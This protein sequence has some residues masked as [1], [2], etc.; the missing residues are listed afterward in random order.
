MV[1][2]W[3]AMAWDRWLIYVV[4][5]FDTVAEYWE[6]VATGSPTRTSRPARRKPTRSGD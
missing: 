3:L 6:S 4:R 1:S 2:N 5:D